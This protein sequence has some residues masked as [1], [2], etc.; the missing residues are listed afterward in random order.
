M[1]L[2]TTVGFSKAALPFFAWNRTVGETVVLI[3]QC[4]PKSVIMRTG[5]NF[6]LSVRNLL[7]TVVG[8]ELT[9]C[10]RP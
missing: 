8:E 6:L 5:L 10:G 4:Y 2:N 7:E 3:H 9:H 1:R